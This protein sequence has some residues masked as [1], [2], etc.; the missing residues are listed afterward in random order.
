MGAVRDATVARALYRA[1]VE[2]PSSAT[3][4]W[5]ADDCLKA[6]FG[7]DSDASTEHHD[8]HHKYVEGCVWKTKFNTI[9]NGCDIV[10]T[11]KRFKRAQSRSLAHRAVKL[12]KR[13]FLT[14]S[15]EE[16]LKGCED[17]SLSGIAFE[18][19]PVR[20]TSF[21]TRLKQGL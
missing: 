21:F 2:E 3:G 7:I 13:N 12:P 17:F 6:A 15:R 1:K 4:R 8:S 14:L 11:P 5:Q 10:V 18:D 9:S 19:S 20:P 16:L